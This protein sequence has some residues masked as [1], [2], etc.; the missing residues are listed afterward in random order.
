MGRATELEFRGNLR[1]SYSDVYTPAVLD[2]LA[3]LAPLN[4]DR[5][6]IMSARIERRQRRARARLRIGFLDPQ[7]TI[8]RTDL[9]VQDARAGKF[10]G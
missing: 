5:R 3:E 8:P 2:A 9:T 6:E 7:S 10:D 4:R 1:E